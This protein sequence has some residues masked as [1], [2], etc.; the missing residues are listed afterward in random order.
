MRVMCLDDEEKML[1]LLEI[2]LKQIE[3]IDEIILF[4]KAKDAFDFFK[5]DTVDVLLLDINMPDIDGITFAKTVK[6]IHSDLKIIFVTGYSE[7]KEQALEAN[8][9]GYLVKPAS[10]EEIKRAINYVSTLKDVNVKTRIKAQCFGNF[11]IF[12]D[13]VPMKF[14]RSKTKE[15]LAYLIDRKGAAVNAAEICAVV[16]EDFDDEVNAQAYFRKCLADLKK[17]LKECNAENLLIADRNSYAVN[18]NVFWCDSY[19][20]DKGNVEVINA[21]HGEYMK[22]YSWAEVRTWKY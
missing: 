14:E 16:W 3:G 12:C 1:A 10:L 17:T 11:E 4:S 18:I 9:N 5:D 6:M 21:Y 13:G 2:R 15:L 7:Y 8:C 22:Q 19:E 20:F